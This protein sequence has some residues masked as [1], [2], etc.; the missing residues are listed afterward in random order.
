MRTFVAGCIWEERAYLLEADSVIALA[1]ELYTW[2]LDFLGYD[3]GF[4]FWLSVARPAW[5][6]R[7]VIMPWIEVW[8]APLDHAPVI[9]QTRDV[10]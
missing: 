3:Y 9:E 5:E 1:H 4:Q 7:A 2:A 10:A 8:A 6:G